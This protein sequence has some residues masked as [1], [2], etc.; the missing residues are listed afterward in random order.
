MAFHNT[1]GALGEK[2]ATEYLIKYGYIIRETNW[3]C[4]KLE[5]DIVAEHANRIIVVEVKTRST[6]YVSPTDAI[7][8]KK[9]SNLV[10]AA[11]VYLQANDLPHEVQ[12]DIITLVGSP[13]NFTI[14]HIPDAFT[15]PLRTYR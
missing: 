11:N 6:D 10:R 2:A 3:R 8:R 13:D 9:I 5:I 14:D 7:D 1:F 4:D 15:A 12:F